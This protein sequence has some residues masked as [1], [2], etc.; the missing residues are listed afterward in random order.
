M[1]PSACA[2]PSAA[3]ICRKMRLLRCHGSSCPASRARDLLVQIV[4]LQ[5][6]HREEH[7]PLGRGAEVADV[8]HVLV[9]DAR[10]RARLLH[11]PL[12]EV[13]LARELAVQHLERH[14]LLE[15]VV[16]REVHRAHAALAELLLDQVAAGERAPEQRIL[17]RRQV[18]RARAGRRLAGIARDRRR[19]TRCRHRRRCRRRRHSTAHPCHR[20]NRTGGTYLGP[21]VLWHQSHHSRA[22]GGP[23]PRIAVADRGHGSRSTH[24]DARIIA[25]H[26]CWT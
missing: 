11:E 8:D 13:G 3:Q 18:R 19:R 25:E 15:Q 2:A 17:A 23:G 10:R 4:A 1:M 26:T 6:L 21:L 9:A 24:S 16:G 12:D 7:Q 14:L 22:E 20:A 5:Q